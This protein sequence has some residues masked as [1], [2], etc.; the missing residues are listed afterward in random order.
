MSPESLATLARELNAEFSEIG[1]DDERASKI[2]R[3]L[4]LQ[5][6]DT[7]TPGRQRAAATAAGVS[8]P[9]SAAAA[10]A[11]LD[12]P[13]RAGRAGKRGR[14]AARRTRKRIAARARKAG[15]ST[16]GVLFTQALGLTA[17]YWVL[18]YPKAVTQFT[19][20]LARGFAWLAAPIPFGGALP[21][22]NASTGTSG[23]PITDPQ[24]PR[25]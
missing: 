22:T 8:A 19:D 24:V 15:R 2:A 1:D 21:P 3:A 6:P 11:L 17:L 16:A 25:S 9:P 23:S 12:E 7:T 18:R 4:R 13:G 20:G 10:T 5:R 14:K